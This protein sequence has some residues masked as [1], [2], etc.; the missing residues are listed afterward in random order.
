MPFPVIS[1][2]RIGGILRELFEKVVELEV[3]DFLKTD[4]VCVGVPDDLGGDV[5]SVKPRVVAVVGTAVADVEGEDG[6]LPDVQSGP[7]RS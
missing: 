1:A 7:K 2:R 4:D 6:H 5:P 3:E